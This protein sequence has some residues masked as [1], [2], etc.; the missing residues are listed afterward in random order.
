MEGGEAEKQDTIEKF[1]RLNAR[2]IVAGIE[3]IERPRRFKTL[4]LGLKLNHPRNVAIMHPLMFTI[5]R[6]IYAITIVWLPSIRLYGIWILLF[7]T[8]VMLC[9]ALTEKPWHEDITSF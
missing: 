4:Y 9:Y 6:I 5:R 8:L 1:A 7:S 2:K 3:L